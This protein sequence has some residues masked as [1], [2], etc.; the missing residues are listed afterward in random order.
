MCAAQCSYDSVGKA[1]PQFIFDD[2]S[3]LFA[4]AIAD[5][6]LYGFESIDDLKE[7]QI[8]PGDKYVRLPYKEEACEWPILRKCDR[9][10]GVT[11][12]P[13]AKAKFLDIY[14]ETLRNA[15]YNCSTSIHS[16]RRALGKKV[17][18]ERCA[19][20]ESRVRW[21]GIVVATG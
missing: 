12:E 18:G 9:D 10:G 13:M 19:H 21:L 7:Q 4:L 11:K 6:A 1:H 14:R 5:G 3:F 8:P 16:I 15:G 2:A 17:D 20:P